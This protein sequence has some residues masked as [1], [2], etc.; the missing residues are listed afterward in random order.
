VPTPTKA[1]TR[2]QLIDPALQRAGWDLNNPNLTRTESPTDGFDPAAWKAL[3]AQLDHLCTRHQIADVDL[4]TGITD[5]A[6][7]PPKEIQDDHDTET[8]A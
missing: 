3:A 2:R 5:C 1:Q 7:Y 8:I 6:P 4:P